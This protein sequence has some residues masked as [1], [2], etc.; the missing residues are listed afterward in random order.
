M[1]SINRLL[2]MLFLVEQHQHKHV[3]SEPEYGSDW[4]RSQASLALGD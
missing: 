3:I 1:K 4:D 2:F